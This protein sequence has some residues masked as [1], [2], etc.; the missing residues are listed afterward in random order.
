MTMRV[1]H[2]RMAAGSGVS[3]QIEIAADVEA[4]IAFKADF[5]NGI[6]VMRNPSEDA[7]IEVAL[8]RH[9]PQPGSPEDLPP[10]MFPSALPFFPIMIMLWHKF[11]IS[12]W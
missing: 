11:G 2:S 4:G 3:R 5:L 1:Q 9:R 12:M 6:I 7:R 8:L 10:K